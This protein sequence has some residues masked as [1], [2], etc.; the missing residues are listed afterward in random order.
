[1]LTARRLN[2][3][4]NEDALLELYGDDIAS[5]ARQL[6]AALGRNF[7]YD[8]LSLVN[9]SVAKQDGY[10]TNAIIE[11]IVLHETVPL[12]AGPRTMHRWHAGTGQ[13]S[14]AL[15]VPPNAP[16]HAKIHLQPGIV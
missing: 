3:L 12:S 13:I 1:M 14:S 16:L 5:F 11:Q 2:H 10:K 8:R 7:T 15:S 4:P 9:I 6:A